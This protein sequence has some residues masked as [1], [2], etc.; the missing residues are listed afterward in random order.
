MAGVG[1]GGRSLIVV[2]I[3]LRSIGVVKGVCRCVVGDRNGVV[4]KVWQMY[5]W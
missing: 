2:S 5:S 1:G 4:V 3:Y